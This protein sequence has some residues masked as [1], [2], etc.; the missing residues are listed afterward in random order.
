[1]NLREAILP[2]HAGVEANK[3][4]ASHSHTPNVREETRTAIAVNTV[5]ILFPATSCFALT[6][7]SDPPK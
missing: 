3:G 6:C 2:A 1:M 7:Y 4:G 5:N